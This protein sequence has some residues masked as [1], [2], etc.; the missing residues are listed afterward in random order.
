[1]ISLANRTSR[2]LSDPAIDHAVTNRLLAAI[3]CRL[4]VTVEHETKAILR[5]IV[6]LRNVALISLVLYGSEARSE[7]PSLFR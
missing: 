5:K 4:N 1:M 7:I 2:A 3:V 6:I